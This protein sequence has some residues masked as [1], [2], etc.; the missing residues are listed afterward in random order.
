MQQQAT[1]ASSVPDVSIAEG[2]SNTEEK[3]SKNSKLKSNKADQVTG[4]INVVYMIQ[5][6]MAGSTRNLL[7]NVTI[8]IS[9]SLDA[10][11]KATNNRLK[12]NILRSME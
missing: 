1:R 7:T 12:N 11:L 6:H 10:F 3:K 9:L 8:Y 2:D 5:S 4:N